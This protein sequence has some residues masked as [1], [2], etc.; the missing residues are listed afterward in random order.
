MAVFLEILTRCF[1][2]P[3]LLAVNQAS[4]DALTDDDWQQTLLVDERGRGIAW[5][6]RFF[7]EYAP[8]LD[9]EYIWILDD[10]DQCIYPDLVHD[11]KA[12][13]QAHDPDV[14]MLRMNHGPRGIL[15]PDNLW[16]VRPRCG[17]VGCSAY[18]VRRSV[19]Q[20]HASAWW[21]GRYTSDY[22]FIN[23][24]WKGG[25]SFHWHDV[26]ASAVQQIGLGQPEKVTP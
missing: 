11:L 25:A 21:S 1:R 24:V 22:D 18:V 9:G 7:A 23:A 6:H 3:T 12:I 20:A 14:I 4:L 10:D 15:P 2:R 17:L 13:V 19:W 8:Q 26:I 16:R 5:T